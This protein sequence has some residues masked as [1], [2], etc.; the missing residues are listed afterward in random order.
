MYRKI[1]EINRVCARQDRD[2][3]YKL[4]LNALKKIQKT[5]SVHHS[6][7]RPTS[8]MERNGSN[9]SFLKK[10]QEDRFKCMQENLQVV[11]SLH[12]NND[13]FDSKE[14]QRDHMKYPSRNF[15]NEFSHCLAS[16]SPVK[17]LKTPQP[18]LYR[19]PKPINISTP[20]ELCGDN[21]IDVGKPEFYEK[22]AELFHLDLS[23]VTRDVDY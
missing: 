18:K 14:Y 7:D 12:Y 6:P 17:R 3:R 9:R 21:R 8:H 22:N 1:P 19:S 16:H 15:H 11:N 4:H 5:G 23:R 10:A 2:R 13:L 20:P